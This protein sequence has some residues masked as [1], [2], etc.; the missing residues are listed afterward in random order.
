MYII[1]SGI[2]LSILSALKMSINKKNIKIFIY[3]M[4][5]YYKAWK[6]NANFIVTESEGSFIRKYRWKMIREKIIGI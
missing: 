2:M 5:G 4:I 1:R 6:M 3:Y